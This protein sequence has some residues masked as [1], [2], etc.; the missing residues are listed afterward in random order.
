M[1]NWTNKNNPGTGFFTLHY[2]N[3]RG[4]FVYRKLISAT[5]YENKIGSVQ[6]ANQF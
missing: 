3:T 5:G 4:V 1:D 2:G 6:I